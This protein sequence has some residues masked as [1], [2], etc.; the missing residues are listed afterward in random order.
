MGCSSCVVPAA[1][2]SLFVPRSLH[3]RPWDLQNPAFF[4]SILFCYHYL[5]LHLFLPGLNVTVA[6]G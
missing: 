1:V 4:L 5:F 6:V 2:S 3:P